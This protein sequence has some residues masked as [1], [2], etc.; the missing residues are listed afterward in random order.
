MRATVG[1]LVLPA[2]LALAVVSAKPQTRQPPRAQYSP[3]AAQQGQHPHEQPQTW[4][5]FA[6]SRLNSADVNYGAS[7]EERRRAF[8]EATVKNPYFN[9]ALSVTLLAFLLMAACAKLVIDTKRKDWVTAEMMTDLMNHEGRSR[10]VAREAIRK[11]NDHIE[12][13]NRVVEAQEFGHA[14]PG[15][16]SNVEQLTTKLRETAE[17]LDAITRERDKLKSDL[18]E[19]TRRVTELSLRLDGLSKKANGDGAPNRVTGGAP[20]SPDAE[21]DTARLMRHINSLQ[22]QLYAERKKNEHLRGG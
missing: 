13:C 14:I 21:S 7:I 4:Y 5:E 6:L 1:C 18:D 3:L 11:Y 19:K 8:L 22:D 17:R 10:E 12:R 2:A 20:A 16:G 9:Y 15:S